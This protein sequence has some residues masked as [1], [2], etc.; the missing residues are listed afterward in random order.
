MTSYYIK[1][2]TVQKEAQTYSKY[3]YESDFEENWLI[4]EA[5][6]TKWMHWVIPEYFTYATSSELIV[7]QDLLSL[8]MEHL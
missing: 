4:S 5:Y 8:F 2:F 6:L 7:S 1:N 3:L